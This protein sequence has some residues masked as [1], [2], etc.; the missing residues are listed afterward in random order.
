MTKA[1]YLSFIL[2]VALWALTSLV[3]HLGYNAGFD[4]DKTKNHD[5]YLRQRQ[6]TCESL[7]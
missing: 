7:L 1:V 2:L 6:R 4:A 3:W 5:W